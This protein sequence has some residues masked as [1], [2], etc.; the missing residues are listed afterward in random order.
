[1]SIEFWQF[2]LVPMAMGVFAAVAC[3]L[4]G[5][6]LVLRRQSLVGDAISHV[7]LPGIVLGFIV[8]GG[9]SA[10]WMLAGAAIAAVIAAIAFEAVRRAARVEAGAAM[11]VVFTAMFALGVLLLEQSD[12][13]SVHVDVEHAL[14]GNLESHI[15]LAGTDWSALFR[16]DAL[17]ALPS[18]VVML[19]VV[20]LAL[21]ALVALFFKELR[22]V[23]FDPD[24]ARS[25]GVP[26]AAIG[27]GVILSAAF[28]AVTAF[29]AVGSILVIAMFICPAA[30][31]RL[32]TNNLA[33]QIW[34]SIAIGALSAIIGF[35]AAGHAPL[36]LGFQSTVSAAGMIAV[37]SGLFVLGAYFVG[38]HLGT[39]RRN[40]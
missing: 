3:T 40:A 21:G 7:V 35:V 30:A 27:F 31:A 39:A 33:T 37:V 5:N 18:E 26:A 28:A 22:L 29:S 4:A 19:G 13:R 2:S 23:T 24:Y 32:L 16:A 8:S 38:L 6:F 10:P 36:W 17:A 20:T 9:T 15:W 12:A 34:L 14:Y 11:G 1:M 25:I